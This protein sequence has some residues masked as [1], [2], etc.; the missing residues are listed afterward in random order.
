MTGV[1]TVLITLDKE[2]SEQMRPPR[3]INPEGFHWGH[4]LGLAG[5]VDLQMNVL[6][7]ALRQ[8]EELHTPGQ[9]RTLRFA[10]YRNPVEVG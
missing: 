2:S 3:A 10:G 9:V 1:P 6:K 4:S 5:E 8:L 7:T